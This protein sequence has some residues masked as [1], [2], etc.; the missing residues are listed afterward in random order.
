[1]LDLYQLV[2]KMRS[3]SLKCLHHN[4]WQ[5]RGGRFLPVLGIF[6]IWLRIKLNMTGQPEKN[7]LMYYVCFI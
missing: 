7:I 1:M 6:G 5:Q 2:F 4:L 3:Y